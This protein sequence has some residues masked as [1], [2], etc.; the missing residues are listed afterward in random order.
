M[1]RAYVDQVPGLV[2]LPAERQ[3][4]A[5]GPHPPGQQLQA[6]VAG[7]QAEGEADD[8]QEAAYSQQTEADQSDDRIRTD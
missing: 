4:P 2:P 6:G 3:A 1:S 7:R 8:Q 5:V